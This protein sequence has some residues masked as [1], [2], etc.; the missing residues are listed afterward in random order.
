[1]YLSNTLLTDNK[2][3]NSCQNK[4][5]CPTRINITRRITNTTKCTLM[6]LNATAS[7]G[8]AKPQ[9]VSRQAAVS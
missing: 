7:I 6:R 8:R 5:D 3:A 1:M 2:H 9:L 4:R